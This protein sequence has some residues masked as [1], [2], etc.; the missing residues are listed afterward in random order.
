MA[1]PLKRRRTQGRRK[2]TFR[3]RLARPRKARVTRP[4]KRYVQRAIRHRG[5]V[6]AHVFDINVTP[7]TVAAITG[8]VI[9][10]PDASRLGLQVGIN[11]THVKGHLLSAD[12]TR[13]RVRVLWFRWTPTTTPSVGDILEPLTGSNVQVDSQYIFDKLKRSQFKVMRDRV[14]HV[15]GTQGGSP[16]V[17]TLKHYVKVPKKMVYFSTGSTSAR[18][19][20]YV[21]TCSDSAGTPHPI[22]TMSLRTRFTQDGG[23]G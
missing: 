14:Y 18:F 12:S 7:S 3:K 4:V 13:G 5:E 23:I 20:T 15:A 19:H 8:P 6:S 9:A 22:L 10:I 17:R 2:P 16:D 11:S 1:P 21:L